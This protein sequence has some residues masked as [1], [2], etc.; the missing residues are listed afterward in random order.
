[1]LPAATNSQRL[2]GVCSVSRT[3]LNPNKN[4]EAP[5]RYQQVEGRERKNHQLES[6][7]KR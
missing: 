5:H 2:L 7:E 4:G 3:H 1:M 6:G